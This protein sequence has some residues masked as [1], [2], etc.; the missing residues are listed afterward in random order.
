MQGRQSTGS[1]LG[2][3]QAQR[4][5]SCSAK[6]ANGALTVDGLD[7]GGHRGHAPLLALVS[8]QGCCLPVVPLD[9]DALEHWH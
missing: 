5:I 7:D 9:V 3:L 8:C 4:S 1:G 6:Q 2:A